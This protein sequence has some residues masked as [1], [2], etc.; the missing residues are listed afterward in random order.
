MSQQG[1]HI[2][3]AINAARAGYAGPLPSTSCP[4]GGVVGVTHTTKEKGGWILR[5]LACK[6]CGKKYGKWSVSDAMLQ[7]SSDDTE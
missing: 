2:Q 4:C 6:T 5:R 3:D 7:R 1:R